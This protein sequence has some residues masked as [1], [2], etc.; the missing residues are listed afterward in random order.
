[1][2]TYCRHAL[3]ILTL[4]EDCVQDWLLCLSAVDKKYNASTN[5]WSNVKLVQFNY[6]IAF[7]MKA[8]AGHLTS[9]HCLQLVARNDECRPFQGALSSL[10][11]IQR[12]ISVE[13]SDRHAQMEE[14]G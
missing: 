6:F 13:I 2:Y 10:F 9:G 4:L 1:M 7:S 3:V 5:T 11:F 14:C 12:S 8:Y